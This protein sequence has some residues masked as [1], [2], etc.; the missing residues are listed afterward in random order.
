MISINI[1]DY[2]ADSLEVPEVSSDVS[3]ITVTTKSGIKINNYTEILN[4]DQN[5]DVIKL[6]KGFVTFNG[7][8]LNITYINDKYIV[9][10]G[11]VFTVNFEGCD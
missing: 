5:T 1:I 8:N 9:L 7:N 11:E 3:E 2:L 4:Y 10:S 6:N